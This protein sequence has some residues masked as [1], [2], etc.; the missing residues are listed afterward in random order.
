MK[1]AGLEKGVGII[2][3]AYTKDPTDPQWQDTP[4]Y[5]EWLTWMKKYNSAG[6]VADAFTVYG[7][8]TAQTLVAVLK[9]CGD[10]LTRENVMKEAAR[11]RDLK[12][13]MLLPDITISTAA[14]DYAPIKQM[15]LQKFDGNTWKVFGD[16]MTGSGT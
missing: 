8:S 6:N 3:A 14:G 15:Q 12:L 10:N 5:K 11:L 4:E 13:P 2:S 9:A 16:V 1:P 7:Y